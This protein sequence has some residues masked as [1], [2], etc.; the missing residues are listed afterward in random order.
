MITT[1]QKIFAIAAHLGY[2]IGG[3]SLIIVPLIIFFWKKED[4]FIADH[5]KQALVAQTSLTLLAMA[6]SALTVILVGVL[7]LPILAIVY[8]IFVVT[9]FVAAYKAF[10]GDYYRYPFVQGIAQK[11]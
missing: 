10:Q 11:L 8:L 2:L 5:A 4:Y 6:V 1:E 9:S 7:F 3:I